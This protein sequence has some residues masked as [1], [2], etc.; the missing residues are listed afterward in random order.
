[1]LRSAQPLREHGG[2]RLLVERTKEVRLPDGPVLGRDAGHVR[3]GQEVEHLQ[4]LDGLDLAGEGLDQ[5]G[6]LEVAALGDVAHAQVRQ[7]QPL[8]VPRVRRVEAD[9]LRVPAHELR[10]TRGVV[11]THSLPQIVE[12]Q[13]EHQDQRALLGA[14]N[15]RQ[16]RFRIRQ[17][18]GTEPHHVRQRENGVRIDGVDVVEAVLRARA[19]ARDL[20]K[21][22]SH[23]S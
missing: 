7:D 18:A 13:S 21:E 12:Q 8:D 15:A 3:V 14:G 23:H 2:V 16:L 4:A 1:M 11:G 17:R 10:S 19:Q 20:G 9:A 5:R 22:R 6:I